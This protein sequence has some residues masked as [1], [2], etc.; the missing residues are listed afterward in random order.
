MTAPFDGT[1]INVQSN[2]FYVK[3]I[4]IVYIS[5]EEIIGLPKK[6]LSLWYK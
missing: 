6:F 4:P 3:I 5:V 1:N 2:Y